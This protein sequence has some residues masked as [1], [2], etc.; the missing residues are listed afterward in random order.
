MRTF[1]FGMLALLWVSG[2]TKADIV[3]NNLAT[4]TPASQNFGANTYF[5]QM[6]TT[7]SSTSSLDWI[8]INLFKSNVTTSGTFSVSIYNTNSGQP[9]SIVGNVLATGQSIDSLGTSSTGVWELGG[10]IN[11][12]ATLAATT[13]Y[14]LVV[15]ANG[16]NSDFKWAMG[17]TSPADFNNS[18]N[19]T[20]WNVSTGSLGA[21][22]AVPEPGTLLLGGIAALTGGGGVWWKRRRKGSGNSA[23]TEPAVN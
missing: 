11:I 20:I 23:E 15:Q 14:W 12:G 17:P 5:A 22:I 16:V 8:K 9:G 19:G 18:N 2:L 1:I 7:T 3:Y 13:N 4:G 10:G 21:Q 6:F